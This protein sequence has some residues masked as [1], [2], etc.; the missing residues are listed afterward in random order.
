M[1][2]A[3]HRL[4]NR[5]GSV[6]FNLQVSALSFTATASQCDDGSLG[7]VFLESHKADSTAG[8]MASD[9]AIAVALA[10]QFGCQVE[11]LCRDA[12]GKATRP[13]DVALDMLASENEDKAA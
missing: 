1:T 9:A 4:P 13:F 10:M 6:T 2:A 3:R 5:R 12:R 8:I 11:T 7:E